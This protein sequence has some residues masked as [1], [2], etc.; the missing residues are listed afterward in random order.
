MTVDLKKLNDKFFTDP[1]WREME[2]LIET[3]LA[4]FRDVMG[5]K[6]TLSNDEI[7]TEVRGRQLM[8]ENLDKFLSDSSVLRSKNTRQTISYK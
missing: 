5:I 6:T 2:E 4:P 3:Y 8:I 1:D 7:A